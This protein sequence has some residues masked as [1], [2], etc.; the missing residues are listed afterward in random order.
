MTS[1]ATYA[2]LALSIILPCAAAHA[3]SPIAAAR[4]AFD[5][6]MFESAIANCE[7]ALADSSLDPE[8]RT[9]A[10]TI[11]AKALLDSD[12]AEEAL[13]MA[14][15]AAAGM[16]KG[17]A[18]DRLL[19]IQSAALLK[20]EG[21]SDKA[22]RL[23]KRI[24]EECS[25]PETRSANMLDWAQACVGNGE[26]EE[27]IAEAIRILKRQQATCPTNE[28][29][30]AGMLLLSDIIA[31]SKD[32]GTRT[33]LLAAVANA[34]WAAPMQRANAF[35]RL[36]QIA[37][38][39]MG[40]LPLACSYA[41]KALEARQ[42]DANDGWAIELVCGDI[43][44]RD[45][46]KIDKGAKAIKSALVRRPND[47][48]AVVAQL[49]LAKAYLRYGLYTNAVDEFKAYLESYDDP[50]HVPDARRGLAMALSG[51]GD[52]ELAATEFARAADAAMAVTNI[53]LA[54]E[55]RLAE[56][57]S[58]A[59]T[60]KYSEA[61]ECYREIAADFPETDMAAR[62]FF[63]RADA[64]ERA[65]NQQ[66]ALDAFA[67]AVKAYS[68]S[69]DKAE[70]FYRQ[71][72]IHERG[73][74]PEGAIQCYTEAISALSAQTANNGTNSSLKARAMLARGR[75]RVFTYKDGALADINFA[76]GFKET[77]EEAS[78]LKI[79]AL[80]NQKLDA[81]AAGTCEKFLAA[82]PES[83]FWIDAELWLAKYFFND[84]TDYRRAEE[85][86]LDTVRHSPSNRWADAALI[87]AGRS[88][89]RRA[90]YS[91][92]ATHFDEVAK[93][94]PESPR[95]P[96]AKFFQADA[97]I[98]MAR[99]E[100]AILL[101]DQITV[102]WPDSDWTTSAMGRKGDCLFSLGADMA[103]RYDEAMKAYQSVRTRP[104][105]AFA[106]MLQAEF[107]IG[108]CL[109]KL[110]RLDEARK[111]YYDRVIL[112]FDNS[113]SQADENAQSW[114]SR[115]AFQL[116]DILVSQGGTESV[117][118][119]RNILGRIAAKGIAGSDEAKL[120]LDKF[121]GAARP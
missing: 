86:F 84:K 51:K 46:D 59:S 38:A 107:K 90:D 9:E 62:A 78:Y 121:D 2:A 60:G 14:E 111:Q 117:R 79:Q 18:L 114:Y 37:D 43:L 89:L 101:L 22:M 69:T 64:L 42:S 63:Q 29:L 52:L 99:F 56:A 26:S 95:I 113:D 100:D 30:A 61:E 16:R 109:E 5:D 80:Y 118:T 39:Q 112:R 106:Q 116:A 115:A 85:L 104:D 41:E 32:I 58:L 81:E 93:S 34:D 31:T 82:F 54:V 6:G 67:K 83:H 108:R 50:R 72:L 77:E 73:N 65:G 36:A 105:A 55:C 15:K 4:I 25:T 66:A 1:R 75:T 8:E 12:R 21:T 10:Q 87:W 119:A 49:N 53:G 3:D 103:T 94:Y 68:N 27:S 88:A 47:I 70:A 35:A 96:E 19:R 91:V 71:G 110:G 92:A 74:E 120:R 11:L 97:L 20:A 48:D 40:D 13:S 44:A 24:D 33:D 102:R 76:C 17:E 98:E 7:K 28:T 23:F 57:E 45:P